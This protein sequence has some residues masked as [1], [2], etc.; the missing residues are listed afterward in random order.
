MTT[1]KGSIGCI[2]IFYLYSANAFS[3]NNI[4]H[5]I[6]NHVNGTE[7]T[8]RFSNIET[9]LNELSFKN[10]N[11][12]K[13]IHCSL[14]SLIFFHAFQDGCVVAVLTILKLKNNCG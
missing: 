2:L 13:T 5:Q 3:Q 6:I 1:M 8:I 4:L 14:V 11:E 12:E 7:N 10:C 9:L